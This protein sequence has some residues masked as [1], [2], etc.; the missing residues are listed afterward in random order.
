MWSLRF[1]IGHA[2]EFLDS[3]SQSRYD[4]VPPE[5]PTLMHEVV[6]IIVKIVN[7]KMGL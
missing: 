5:I 1:H 6:D 3:P 2:L 7:R 4:F